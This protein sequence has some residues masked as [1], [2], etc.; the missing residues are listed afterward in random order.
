ME[1]PKNVIRELDLKHEKEN[2]EKAF[3]T[4]EKHKFKLD[5]ETLGFFAGLHK[6][7]GENAVESTLSIA[8]EHK[9]KQDMAS[10]SRLASVFSTFGGKQ[11]IGL[12][13]QRARDNGL[14]GDALTVEALAKIDNM[15]GYKV[16]RQGLDFAQK[17]KIDTRGNNL[18]HLLD[19]YGAYGIEDVGKAIAKLKRF[20]AELSGYAVS[21]VTDMIS[22]NVS[23][24]EI[25]KEI[26][27]IKS[28]F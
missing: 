25:K 22:K 1:I 5:K 12:A 9:I 2:V 3:K 20:G 23:E 19:A 11:A 26:Q 4:I 17:N 18:Y 7:Y 6:E 8:L 21:M 24:Q 27:H 16:I 15:Y 10:I 14:R 28:L 13:V